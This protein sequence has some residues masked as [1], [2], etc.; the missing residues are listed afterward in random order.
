MAVMYTMF[1]LMVFSTVFGCCVA[2]TLPP[3]REQ[4]VDENTILD[5]AERSNKTF[6]KLIGLAIQNLRCDLDRCSQWSQWTVDALAPGQFGVKTRSRNCWYDSCNKTGPKVVENDN[7]IYEGNCPTSYNVTNG[8]F[9]LAHYT[10]KMNHSA[11]QQTCEKDGGHMINID[12]KERYEA[13]LKLTTSNY[14]H[15]EG[16]RKVESGHFY[17]DFGRRIQD[18]PFFKWASG[19]PHNGTSMFVVVK[20]SEFFDV[21]DGWTYHVVCEI[22]Q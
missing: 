14:F 5:L 4:L 21:T 1:W 17:D 18:R 3:K 8:K 22:R 19:E 16:M 15:V 6:L 13:A 2:A 11:A 12:T 20:G 9:C 7:T 10:N